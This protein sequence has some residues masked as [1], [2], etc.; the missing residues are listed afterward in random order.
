MVSVLAQYYDQRSVPWRGFDLDP[1][2]A[3]F[4]RLFP[5]EVL[6]HP[7]GDEPEADIIK[8]ARRC[9]DVPVTLVDPRAHL[10]EAILRGWDM[11]QF[12]THFAAQGGRITVVLFPGDDLEILTDID[13]LVSRLGDKVDYLVVRN[14]ARQPRTRM[15]DGSPLEED[16]QRLGAAFVE[17]PP[18]LAV[19]RNHLSALEAELGRG[20]T[21][22][23]AV[24]NRE[25]SL[26]SMIRLVVEDWIRTVFRRFDLVADKLLPSEYAVK[27]A[28]VDNAAVGSA[29]RITRG[30]K[31]N[32]TNL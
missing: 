1:E 12:P 15:F 13:G 2:H 27:I 16:L 29:P 21:H 3:T 28:R 6:L 23:E 22:L 19:A 32:K 10:S 8:I 17:L 5:D 20:V 4:S 7:L 24:A 9:T 30:A 26:D 25:L 18:L 11:I 14:P 31:I